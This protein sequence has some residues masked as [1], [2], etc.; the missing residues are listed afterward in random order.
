[1]IMHKALHPR[2]D[3]N[4]LYVSRKER[5]RGLASIEDR[6]DASIKRLEDYIEKHDT[7]NAV[8][9]KM[10][11][12]IKQKWEK[13]HFGRFKRLINISSHKKT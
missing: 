10:T 5:G 3:V 8:I 13:Q 2:D 4:R 1:M 12:T 6:V 11:I 7:D 9:N